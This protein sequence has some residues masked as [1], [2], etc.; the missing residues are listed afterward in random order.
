M[1]GESPELRFEREDSD[2][3]LVEVVIATSTP[4]T[5]PVEV[6]GVRFLLVSNEE[7]R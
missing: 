3:G 4:R 1:I 7:D 6:A 2:R 5:D